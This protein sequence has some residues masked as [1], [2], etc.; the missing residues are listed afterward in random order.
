LGVR[1]AT[2]DDADAVAGIYAPYVLDTTISFE[3]VPPTPKE[4]R[5]R[6]TRLLTTYP[7]LVFDDDGAVRAYAYAGPHAERAA[8]RWSV[9]VAVYA[10]RGA[11]R[12]G[13]GRSLYAEL[14]RILERQGFHSA[15]AGIALPNA[16][17]VGLH[18]AMGFRHAGT[19]PAVGFKH[20]AWRDLGWWRRPLADGPPKGEPIPFPQL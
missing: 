3:A 14:F 16:G 13:M 20:G 11:Q 17:S 8:Y 18:E 7:W 4:M 2:P 10:Q 9:D 19:H 12:Q 15:W 5:E 1:I 6:I